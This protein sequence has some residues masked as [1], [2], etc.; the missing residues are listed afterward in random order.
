MYTMLCQKVRR[1]IFLISMFKCYGD[2]ATN[3]VGK[4]FKIDAL[5]E[6]CTMKQ[7]VC[8]LKSYLNGK[9]ARLQQ[10]TPAHTTEEVS[11]LK[12]VCDHKLWTYSAARYLL[13]NVN[14]LCVHLWMVA[15]SGNRWQILVAICL[16]SSESVPTW[17][18]AS[19]S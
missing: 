17:H 10:T 11:E 7:R 12:I 8:S 5:C 6:Y 13:G 3:C 16:T 19:C 2:D 15:S 18:V 14:R 4:R 9:L 1:S